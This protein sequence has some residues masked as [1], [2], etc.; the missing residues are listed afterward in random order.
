MPATMVLH[1]EAATVLKIGRCGG[2]KKCDARFADVSTAIGNKDSRTQSAACPSKKEMARADSGRSEDGSF[3]GRKA[4]KW[5]MN[6]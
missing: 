4:Q 6:Q 1:T 5:L 3:S 2:E